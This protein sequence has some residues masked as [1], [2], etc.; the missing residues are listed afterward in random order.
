VFN[1]SGENEATTGGL[2]LGA[3]DENDILDDLLDGL[4][5]D[6]FD[7]LLDDLLDSL[8]DDLFDG[9]LDD[10]LD[11]LMDGDD[12]LRLRVYL[13]FRLLRVYLRFLL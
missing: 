3:D 5:D 1:I 11:G 12:D 9:L 7:G 13:L 8:F 2:K 4:L 6:L 10:L